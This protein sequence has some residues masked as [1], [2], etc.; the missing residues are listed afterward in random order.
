MQQLLVFF[1]EFAKELLEGYL[2]DHGAHFDVA[3]IQ[4]GQCFVL[5][6]SGEQIVGNDR[7]RDFRPGEI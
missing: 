3:Q 4:V 5:F 7:D 2:Y 6:E 1:N